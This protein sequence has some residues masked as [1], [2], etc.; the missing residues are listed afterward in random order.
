MFY[1]GC[2]FLLILVVWSVVASIYLY[3]FARIILIL[4]NDLSEATEVLQDA[5][6][7]LIN[8]LELPMFF[9]SPEVQRATVDALEGI[10]TAKLSVAGLVTKFTQR[11]K[12]KYVEFVEVAREE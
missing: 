8:V 4:E 9:D 3:R 7:T 5:E 11:S 2:I 6:K 1:L 10:K 12:Q